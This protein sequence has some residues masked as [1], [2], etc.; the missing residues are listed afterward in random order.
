MS[1]FG[2]LAGGALGFLMG[3]P[4]GAA[5]GATLGH[6][7]DAEPTVVR[8]FESGQDPRKAEQLQRAF[9]VGLFRL[10]G[11][12]AKADG[13]VSETEI[14]RARHIMDRLL[15]PES[16]RLTAM[17]CFNQGRDERLSPEVLLGTLVE[18][19]RG[20]PA[21]V[22]FFVLL[23]TEAALAEGYLHPAKE[24]LLLEA[25][26]VI[27]FSRLEFS[28]LRLRLEAEWKLAA[29]RG[30]ARRGRRGPET[31]EWRRERD[32]RWERPES[33]SA[34]GTAL[35]A[36]YKTLGL[37]RAATLRDVKRAYRLMISRHHPDKLTAQG[38]GPSEIQKATERTQTIQK[39]Y[40]L[41]TRHRSA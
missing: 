32:S 8:L 7:F 11:Q 37:P 19:L 40:E 15:L 31:F 30:E 33:L 20:R 23:E 13:R 25:C 2:K 22:R 3:G 16:L 6:Q 10:M 28:G 14:E 27:G 12:I 24:A 35:D 17:R 38:A 1:W 39:A 26:E 18:G 21:L 41:I 4:L 29:F 36:A 34:P 9:F 5:L